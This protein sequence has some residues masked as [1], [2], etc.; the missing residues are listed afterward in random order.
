MPTNQPKLL[1]D[2]CADV[3]EDG[4]IIETTTQLFNV[5]WTAF[6]LFKCSVVAYLFP[7]IINIISI[8]GGISCT[9]IMITLPGIF[10]NV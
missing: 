10:L 2:S 8:L 9:G 6:I 1:V 4:E 3:E 7:Q 5:F